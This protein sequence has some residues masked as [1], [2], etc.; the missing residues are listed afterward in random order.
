M[1][2]TYKIPD[3]KG[4]FG[5]FGGRFIPETLMPAVKELTAAYEKAAG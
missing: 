5:R 1:R 3:D 4:Y 2:K